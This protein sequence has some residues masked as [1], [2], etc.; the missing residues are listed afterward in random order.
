MGGILIDRDHIFKKDQGKLRISWSKLRQFQEC[1][2]SWFAINYASMVNVDLIMDKTK[3]LPGVIVQK[4]FETFINER[5]YSSPGMESYECLIEWF[6]VNTVALFDLIAKPIEY[7]SMPKY[8]DARHYFSSKEGKK[9]VKAAKENFNLDYRIEAPQVNFTNFDSLKEEYGS[10]EGFIEHLVGL[11]RPIL[12]SF[13]KR[14]LN[15]DLILSEVYIET[16]IEG[17]CLNGY[18]DFLYNQ[19]QGAGFF[20][21]IKQLKDCFIIYDGKLK[22]SR[23]IHKEQLMYYAALLQNKYGRMPDKVGF[24][25]WT[26]ARIV[27]HSFEKEYI[28][29][30]EEKVKKMK[31]RYIQLIDFFSG[32]PLDTVALGDVGLKCK[33]NNNCIFCPILMNCRPALEHKKDLID[34]MQGAMNRKKTKMY[35][36]SIGADKNHKTQDIS[37]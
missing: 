37:L 4:L 35:L 10:V 31:E 3:A 24:M 23:Y 7:Q 9:E 5:I 8:K 36:K 2:K 15:L 22:L 18:I 17:V 33:P 16:E 6:R 30:L 20:T 14:K 11:Y 28:Y 12:D 19:S 32:Y 27:M 13:L 25:G 21:D 26:E 29:T 1:P 34:Y